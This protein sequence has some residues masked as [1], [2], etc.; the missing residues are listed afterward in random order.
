LLANWRTE[1]IFHLPIANREVSE[2]ELRDRYTSLIAIEAHLPP[3]ESITYPGVAP[4]TLLS[5]FPLSLFSITDD[6][7]TTTP[8]PS[9][10]PPQPS[11]TAFTFA[12]YG[13]SGISQDGLHL[14]TCNHC[15]QRVGLWL[16]STE[17]LATMSA[18]IGAEESQL[19]LNLLETHREHCPW[20]NAEAQNNP[21]DGQV[22]GFAAWR[23]LQFMLEARR[24]RNT[25][26]SAGSGDE[27]GGRTE[28]GEKGE[29]IAE[30]W[31][32]LK[33]KLKRTTSKRSLKSLGRG[34][35]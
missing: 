17:R 28:D 29:G 25:I 32:R 35:D 34:K 22:A 4:E 15:F 5:A 10:E 6:P 30:R 19:R 13:W 20:K 3:L 11:L 7:T 12:L 18:K 16:Y 31:Q 21:P 2:T 23:T 24:R 9:T 8:A 27:R 1:D 26:A 33:S 14:A